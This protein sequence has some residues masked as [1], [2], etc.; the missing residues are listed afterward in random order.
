MA[1]KL[2]F[3]SLDHLFMHLS[4]EQ[5]DLLMRQADTRLDD[6]CF[7]FLRLDRGRMMDGEYWMTDRGDCFHIRMSIAAYPAKKEIGV[8]IVQDML[9]HY[10]SERTPS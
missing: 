4:A 8:K 5:I 9:G 6:D 3:R 2:R 10:L 7:F 1:A